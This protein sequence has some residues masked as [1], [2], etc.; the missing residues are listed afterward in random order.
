MILATTRGDEDHSDL[1]FQVSGLRFS[2]LG[3]RDLAL[4]TFQIG[5]K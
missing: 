1:R 2:V 4:G 5:T 3:F